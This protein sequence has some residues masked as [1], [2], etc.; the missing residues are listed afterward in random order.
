[1]CKILSIDGNIIHINQID[2]FDGSP[3]IDIKPYI[4]ATDSIHSADAPG[5]AEGKLRF[6]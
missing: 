3:V 1:M 5:W 4:P 2:A 6:A